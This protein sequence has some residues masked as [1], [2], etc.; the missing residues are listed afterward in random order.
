[1]NKKT[2]CAAVR[3]VEMG[4]ALTVLRQMYQIG[5]IGYLVVGLTGIVWDITADH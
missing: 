1:M 3:I 2:I 4:V 5:L